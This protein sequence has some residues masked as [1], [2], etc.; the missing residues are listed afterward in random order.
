MADLD[1]LWISSK[2]DKTVAETLHALGVVS[3]IWNACEYGLLPIFC[4]VT[5][6][7]TRLAW[8]IIHDLGDVATSNNI[9]DALATS[10]HSV[11]EKEA[12]LYAIDLYDMNRI[13]RNQLTHF[14]PI[15]GL[16]GLALFRQKGP[17]IWPEWF[18]SDL[19]SVRR[20]ADELEVLCA[21]LS[22]VGEYFT[23]MKGTAPGPLPNRPPLPERLW[24]PPPPNRPKRKS[25]P[26]SSRA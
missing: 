13:N 9:R 1:D 21:Y 3:L 2:S 14:M 10:K 19:K 26:R 18:P 12:I 16:D 22:D 11:S 7:D 23:K 20:V 24:K 17:F 4:A 8:I 6:I 25:P 15:F 5:N